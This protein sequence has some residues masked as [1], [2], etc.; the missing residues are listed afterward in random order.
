MT[1]GST[2]NGTPAKTSNAAVLAADVMPV[3]PHSS[4]FEWDRLAVLVGRLPKFV[5]LDFR[6]VGA[7]G[8]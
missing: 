6:Y 8:F 7:A 2:G 4:V 5:L 3:T 1:N